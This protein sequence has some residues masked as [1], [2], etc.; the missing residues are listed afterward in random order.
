[1]RVANAREDENGSA[2]GAKRRAWLD[3]VEG[4]VFI[5]EEEGGAGEVS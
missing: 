4:A 2:A 5:T 3:R 1:M